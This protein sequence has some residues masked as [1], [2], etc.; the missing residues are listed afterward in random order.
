MTFPRTDSRAMALPRKDSR[1]L[2]IV[3]MLA[4]P[5]FR[6]KQVAAEE[7]VVACTKLGAVRVIGL[8]IDPII[9]VRVWYSNTIVV[10]VIPQ[11]KNRRDSYKLL[12]GK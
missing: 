8:L 10:N 6:A 4:V 2:T 1:A 11:A 12:K 5:S 3:C 7:V 9:G